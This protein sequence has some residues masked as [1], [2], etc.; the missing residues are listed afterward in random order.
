MVEISNTPA[1]FI[2]EILFD[3]LPSVVNTVEENVADRFKTLSIEQLKQNPPVKLSQAMV[4]L[5]IN[6]HPN[7]ISQ[8]KIRHVPT[9][10]QRGDGPCGFYMLFNA[11]C[12][13]K[14]LC[15]DTHFG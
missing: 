8:K 5:G 13:A 1:S 10:R 9:Y 14:A 4:D 7:R 6:L 3:L 12:L 2:C 11:K 15:A